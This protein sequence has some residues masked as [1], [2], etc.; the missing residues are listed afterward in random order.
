M[1][2][3]RKTNRRL[4]ARNAALRMIAAE[5]GISFAEARKL[6]SRAIVEVIFPRTA[7]KVARRFVE[8]P[9][10]SQRYREVP[11]G[12]PAINKNVRGPVRDLKYI[13]RVQAMERYWTTVRIYAEAFGMSLKEARKS[14]TRRGV[15]AI[16]VDLGIIAAYDTSPKIFKY[17]APPKGERYDKNY[18]GH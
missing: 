14:Y 11:R 10:Y 18:L 4:R 6:Y 2:K 15:R 3:R 7:Q 16:W 1:R 13:K 5:D 9:I 12:K 17:E 8:Y